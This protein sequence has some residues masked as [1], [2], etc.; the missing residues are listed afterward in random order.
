MAKDKDGFELKE[1]AWRGDGLE[2][3]ILESPIRYKTIAELFDDLMSA[4]PE[5]LSSVPGYDPGAW[6]V[7]V[8]KGGKLAF[9]SYKEFSWPG[10]NPA[11][12]PPPPTSP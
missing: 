3:P 7:P 6:N 2:H 10:H 11:N 4:S 5:A 1:V 8:I 9:L 12:A